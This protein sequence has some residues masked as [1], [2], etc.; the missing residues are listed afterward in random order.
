[1]SEI[2][3]SIPE[4][5]YDYQLV[6]EIF[7]EYQ[8]QLGIDLCFQQFDHELNNLKNI[9]QKPKGIIILAKKAN[10]IVGCVALKP[11]EKNNCEMK[12][13][14][15]KPAHR[16]NG[17]GEKLTEMLIA[18]AQKNKYTLMKLDTLVQLNEAITLYQKLGFKSTN[19]YVFNPLNDVLYFEKEL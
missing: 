14:F 16:G 2:I 17:I 4:T 19:P 9:Y 1:M 12:R 6:V 10:E 8:L 18:Y 13:L 11:I 7:K 15:V 3:Y 5:E